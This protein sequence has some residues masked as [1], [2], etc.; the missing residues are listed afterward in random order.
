MKSSECI[1]KFEQIRPWRSGDKRAPHKPYLILYA[2]ARWQNGETE[3]SY[4]DAEPNL[5]QLLREFGPNRKPYHPENPFW[6][7]KNDGIWEVKGAIKKRGRQSPSAK[8]LRDANAIGSFSSEVLDAFDRDPSLVGEIAQRILEAHFT[9]SY[10]EDILN[11]VGLDADLVIQRRRKRDPGFRQNVLVAYEFRCAVCGLD[12]RMSNDT[13]ALEAAHIRWHNHSGPDTQNNG[14]A[15][16]VIHH[17]LFHRGVFMLSDDRVFLL[18]DL[19]TGTGGF[20]AVVG[21]YHGRSIR[22]AQR[23]EWLPSPEFLGWH[24]EQIFQGSAREM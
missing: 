3:I 5:V 22:D 13:V 4:E 15:L 18:S 24:R 7:L 12:L 14:I 9:P 19:V 23:A 16:C 8:Q 6:H 20:E 11:T 1:E 21:R 17:K 10:E 2:L